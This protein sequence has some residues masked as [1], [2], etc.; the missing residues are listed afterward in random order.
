MK[1]FN[2]L[3]LL[4]LFLYTSVIFADSNQ[5]KMNISSKSTSTVNESTSIKITYPFLQ[6]SETKEADN[7]NK[8]INELIQ[9]EIKEFKNKIA[10]NQIIEKKLPPQLKKNELQANYYAMPPAKN[11]AIISIRF[12]FMMNLAGMAHPY[13]YVAVLNLDLK[14]NKILILKDLF[15]DNS[16]Y[17]DI[18]SKFSKIALSK[19][20]SNKS[21]IDEGT[22]PTNVNF[23]NWNITNRGLLIIFDVGQVAPQV[24]GVQTVV[25]PFP[26]LKTI[27]SDFALANLG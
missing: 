2:R 3:F 6:S 23:K 4:I 16:N 21:M 15:K 5:N 14:K 17:L 26:E 20:L 7:F 19:E 12:D 1:N 22:A 13:N 24:N 8:Q 10:E 18:L 27:F 9:T 25:I 11:A